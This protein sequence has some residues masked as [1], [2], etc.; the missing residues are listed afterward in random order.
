[1]GTTTLNDAATGDAATG[2]AAPGTEDGQEVRD[3]RDAAVPAPPDVPPPGPEF[4]WES[5]GLDLDAYLERIGHTGPVRADLP[6]L[7]ALVRAHTE[8][9]PFENLDVLLRGG[10]SL[11]IGDLQ[12][13]LVRR[14]RG[15]YCHE[16]NG[17]LATVL[18]HVGFTVT[19]LSARMLFGADAATLRPVGHTLLRV[20]VP[21]EGSWIV[22][23]GVG[24]WG[25]SA[26]LPLRNGAQVR[27]GDWL[28][29]LDRT[30]R[31]WMVRLLR[32]DGWFNVHLFTLEPYFRP[33]MADFDYIAS[34]HP[35]SPFVRMI[36]VQR[37]GA[38][39]RVVL[40][41]LRLETHRPD[42]A[43]EVRTLAPEDLPGVLRGVFGL[44]LPTEDE[45]ALVRFA[46]QA[47]EGQEVD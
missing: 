19:A 28:Y 21:G 5:A 44:H 43:P 4:G 10:V 47:P 30:P 18:D 15:G 23:T 20:D 32:H 2:G 6:T 34:H 35:R 33:D 26:P 7:R 1:M 42:R 9:L 14:R 45:Q 41:D 27:A 3:A 12:D 16:L 11:A 13:K 38:S 39:E 17:L 46:A 24:G 36:S 22:D 8:N 29:R 37:N 25:P 40:T 31:G